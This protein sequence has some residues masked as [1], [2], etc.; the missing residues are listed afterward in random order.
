M[1]IYAFVFS[2][3]FW[4]AL[5]VLFSVIE[6][7]TF[8]L[9]TVWFAISALVM[10]FLSFLPIPFRGQVTIFLAVAILLL[11]FT[12]PI[13]VKKLKVGKVK[14]NVEDLAGKHALVT[15]T[16]KEFEK[17]EIRLNGQIWSAKSEDGGTME[18]GTRCEVLR[19]EGVHAVVR[20]LTAPENN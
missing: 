19:I 16:I 1:N 17:G 12:R 4:L 5:V 11:V 8:G 14:T 6:L 13:A 15:K 7:C 10:V 2:P 9:T 20:P 3:W 18:E